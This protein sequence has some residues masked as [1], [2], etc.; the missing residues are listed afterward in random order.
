MD[1]E[2]VRSARRVLPVFAGD[3]LADARELLGLTQVEVASSVGLTSSALSQAERGRTTPSALNLARLALELRVDPGAFAHAPRPSMQMQP[4]FRHVRRT[5]KREQR[6]AGQLVQATARI[7]DL[8]R[9]RVEF[10][11]RFEFAHP[12]DPDA[13]I[14]AVAAEIER[15]A[16]KTRKYLGLDASSP[17]AP[18]IVDPLEAGGIT[19]VRDPE[20]DENIDA[21]SAIVD[22]LPIIILDGGDGSVWDRD[23]FNL[24]HELGH[25][26]MH[27]GI[28]HTPGTKAVEAQA[29][30]FAGAFLA[31]AAAIEDALPVALD[32]TAYLD[33]KRKW[34]LSMAA[35]VRRAKDLGVIDDATYTR[36]M[37]QRSAHGWRRV[38]PGADD[39]PLPEPTHLKK[40]AALADLSTQQIATMT[41]VP[42]SVVER[43]TGQERP[44]LIGA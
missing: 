37:K 30:R 21:Y 23:N 34:G 4:Q 6:K 35:L 28:G 38:E 32:W 15:T 33:L 3:R 9:T 7:G 44:T 29:H 31:P 41:R 8:L 12:V 39:R 11:D 14:E 1:D 5:P 43:I 20:T 26:V 18:S 22:E 24:A 36:A 27:R 17:I 40:A 25:L 16:G 2:L 42:Q 13:P 10:P 19:I